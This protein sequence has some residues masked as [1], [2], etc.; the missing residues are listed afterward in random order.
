[1]SN[2]VPKI[3][4]QFI[5]RIHKVLTVT[6]IWSGEQDINQCNIFSIFFRHIF[7]NIFSKL[8]A[9]LKFNNNF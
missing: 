7:V 4:Q 3:G 9:N 1:M 6:L 2:L 5:E 8:A